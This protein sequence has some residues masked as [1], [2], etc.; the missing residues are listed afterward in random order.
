[1]VKRIF[2]I[3]MALL[4]FETA[5]A[6][7]TI[8]EGK[9]ELMSHPGVVLVGPNAVRIPLGNVLLVRDGEKCGAVI[10]THG[11]PGASENEEVAGYKCFYQGDGSSD[12]SKPNV[13]I[14]EG[15]L[16]QSRL[17]GIGRFSFDLGNKD[18]RCGPLMLAWSGKGWVYFYS[19][20]QKAGDYGI[21]LAPTGWKDIAQVNVLDQR[22]TWYKYD[23]KRETKKVMLSETWPSN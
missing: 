19:T 22:V 5:S 15:K 13:E 2:V 23:P 18:I 20:K 17:F 9:E 21:Q 4:A 1:M 8:E 12:F 11:K 14:T 16:S 6:D 3:L 7:T 10:L